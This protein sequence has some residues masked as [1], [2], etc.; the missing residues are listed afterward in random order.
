MST[1]DRAKVELTARQDSERARLEERQLAE[2]AELEAQ[3]KDG[4][5]AVPDVLVYH[6]GDEP[7]RAQLAER[8]EIALEVAQHV[9]ERA[10]RQDQPGIGRVMRALQGHFDQPREQPVVIRDEDL[11][12]SV[13]R[14]GATPYGQGGQTTG[15]FDP[16]VRITHLPTG[17]TVDCD[18]ERSQ[19]MNKDRALHELARQLRERQS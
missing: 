13:T 4:L 10:S 6:F 1:K 5:A 2:R 9:Y 3:L 11:G 15:D 18:T 17:I 16:Y 14:P 7:T 8:I 19:L 12:I